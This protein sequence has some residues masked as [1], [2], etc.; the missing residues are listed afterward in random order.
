[1]RVFALLASLALVG[2][3]SAG[4]LSLE[5]RPWAAS[6]TTVQVDAGTSPDGGALPA[7]H[8]PLPPG[9]LLRGTDFATG[10]VCSE[11]HSATGTTNVDE[12]GR[13]VGLYEQWAATPMANATRD[14]LFRAALANEIARAPA[15][16]DAIASICLTCHAGMGRH[17]QLRAGTPTTFALAYAATAEGALARDGV[18]CTLCHQIQPTN[19]GADSSFS[20]GYLLGAARQLAGPYAGPFAMPMQN[21]TGFTPVEGRHV[22]DSALCGTC[23]TLVTEALTPAGAGTGHHMGE[24]LTYLEWRRS[25]FTTEGGGS[26]PQSCQSCHMPD[27][28]DD[29]Q[30]LFTRLAHRPDGADFGQVSP[31]GPFSRHTFAGA[32]TLLPRLLR[33]GRALLNPVASDAALADAEQRARDTLRTRAARLSLLDAGH[34][35][36]ALG[37]TVRVENLTGHKFPSGYPSRRAFLHLRVLDGA[38]GLLFESGAVDAA[39]RIVGPDGQPLGAELP[40]GP[41]HP[42]RARVGSAVEVVVYE[43]VLDDGAGRPSFELLAAHGYLKDDRLLPRGHQDATVGPQSTAPVGV[44]DVDF[45]PGF[46]D[47]R[48]ELPLA[49]A[50]A[51]VEV[52][53]RYQTFSPRY[54]EQLLERPTP[55]ATALREMLQPGVLAPELVD[56]AVFTLP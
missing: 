54:L 8:P 53:L 11:C 44:S 19:F 24:Q 18:S 30:P 37:F 51:R 48:F 34:A 16:A 32:D 5:T 42:H 21:R 50:P 46:D 17:S 33:D 27:T 40:G 43:S 29:G 56:E 39:G 3:P 47:V 10:V 6:D 4:A 9:T 41:H 14:P 15:A 1:M 38:G 20:G 26:S 28:R 23:H 45:R 35:A 12:Q 7:A 25:A 49:G 36:G 31:R 13:P 55:E 52:R 2:C 22:Q